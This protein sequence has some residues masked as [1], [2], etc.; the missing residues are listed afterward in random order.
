MGKDQRMQLRFTKT[1]VLRFIGHIDLM[2]LLERL[3]RRARMPLAMSQGFHPKP[4]VSFPSALPLGFCGDDEVLEMEFDAAAFSPEA[5]GKTFVPAEIQARLNEQAVAGLNFVS[6]KSLAANAPKARLAASV[7][8]VFVPENLRAG[9]VNR[10]CKF[11]ENPE[12]IVTKTNGKNL[13]VREAVESLI[14]DEPRG[15]LSAVLLAHKEARSGPEASFRDLL[16][17]LELETQLF[18]TLFPRRTQ[19]RLVDM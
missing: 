1:A 5:T 13:E 9:I 6:V 3:F 11:L 18:R 4:R 2:L 14:W 19:V 8:E 12:C 10:V 7:Y 15:N 17:P 16:V